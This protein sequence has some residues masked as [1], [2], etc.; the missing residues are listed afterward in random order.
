MQTVHQRIQYKCLICT[1]TAS[2]AG[3]PASAY[4]LYKLCA[5]RNFAILLGMVQT[6][7]LAGSADVTKLTD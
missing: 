3:N 5:E 6:A 7:G 1:V 4:W 2:K